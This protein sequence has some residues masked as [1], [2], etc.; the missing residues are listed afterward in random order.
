MTR[1]QLEHLIRAA[2]TITDDD[3]LV[4]I[5]SQSILGQF[6]EARPPVAIQPSSRSRTRSSSDGSR[7]IRSATA[8]W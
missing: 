4:T 8:R 7:A 5:G 1:E 3:E 2:S 6:P